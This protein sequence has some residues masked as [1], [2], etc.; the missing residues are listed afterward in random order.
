[1]RDR[2]QVVRGD[3]TRLDVD[4]IVNSA[5]SKLVAGGG[6]DAAIHRAAGPGR[7]EELKKLSGCEPG[8]AKITAGYS[9]TARHVIH[10]V[11]PTWAGGSRNEPALLA[12]CYR[13][14]LEIA[15][16]H[17]LKTVAFSAISTGAFGYPLG[18]AC[19]IAA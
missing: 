5:N 2:I 3:I 14:S 10:A 12:S 11:G 7:K 9:L 1:M 8:H 17:Q 15:R 18:E 4:A 19:G 6:V 16:D 13:Y